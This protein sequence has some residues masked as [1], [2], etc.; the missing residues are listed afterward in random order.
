VLYI[1]RATHL[2]VRRARYEDNILVKQ[3]DFINL[4]VNT[5]LKDTDF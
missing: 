2:P 1:S 5:G 3:E 4:K